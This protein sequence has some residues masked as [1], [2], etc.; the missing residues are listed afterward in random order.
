MIPPSVRSAIIVVLC[1]LARCVARN[2]DRTSSVMLAPAQPIKVP[3][4]KTGILRLMI[5]YPVST[6]TSGFVTAR[7]PDSFAAG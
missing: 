3:S 7:A 2:R 6:L 5:G 1:G 4:W